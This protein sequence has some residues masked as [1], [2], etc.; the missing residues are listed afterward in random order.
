MQG[1]VLFVPSDGAVPAR[2]DTWYSVTGAHHAP[3]IFTTSGISSVGHHTGLCLSDAPNGD[4]CLSQSIST[5]LKNT[6]NLKNPVSDNSS[7][8]NLSRSPSSAS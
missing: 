3:Q 5:N 1:Y 8:V 4:C 2:G 7:G 6:K